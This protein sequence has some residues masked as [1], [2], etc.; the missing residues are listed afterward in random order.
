MKSMSSSL[1]TS[2]FTASTYFVAILRSF[3][4]LGLAFG[5]TCN[6]CSMTFVLTPTRLEV[7]HANTS[8]F[9]SKKLRISSCSC[10][11]A[12]MLMHTVLSRTLGSSGTFWNSASAS[13]TFLHSTGGWVS[14]CSGFSRRKCTFCGMGRNLSQCFWLLVGCQKWI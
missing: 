3:Y 1:C 12:S 5:L 10:W 9:L 6:Q 2:A 13:M 14:Y 8:L 11:L 4:F 7:D